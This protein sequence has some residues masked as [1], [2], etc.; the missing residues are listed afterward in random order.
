MRRLKAVLTL[1]LFVVVATESFATQLVL[2]IENNRVV[3]AADSLIQDDSGSNHYNDCKIH[4]SG[5]DDYFWAVTGIGHDRKAKFY[6]AI[7]IAKRRKDIHGAESLNA[8]GTSFVPYLQKSLDLIK[9]EAPERYAD[10]VKYKWM[11]S[12]YV[13]DAFNNVREGYVIDFNIDEKGRVVAT[14]A[15]TCDAKLGRCTKVSSISAL[16][17][18]RLAASP[19]DSTEQNVQRIMNAAMMVRPTQV[20][21]PISILTIEPTGARW[22]DKGK[23]GDIRHPTSA[24]KPKAKP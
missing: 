21:P 11:E 7:L 15:I 9:K 14:P 19:T 8:V 10:N 18:H 1:M 24:K 23:C 2:V 5:T 12:L 4:Q 16:K 17:G 13:I 3:L 20:G 6:P 22:L